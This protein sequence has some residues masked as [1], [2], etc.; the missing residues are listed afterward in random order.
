MN[1][2]VAIAFLLLTSAMWAQ[3]SERPKVYLSQN[4]EFSNAFA[5]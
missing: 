3:T 5:A 4:D 1:K 2:L